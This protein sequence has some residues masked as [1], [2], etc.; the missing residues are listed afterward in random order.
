MMRILQLSLALAVVTTWSTG[1]FAQ[2]RGN[3]QVGTISGRVLGRDGAPAASLRVAAMS[4]DGNVTGV[5]ALL[6]LAETDAAGLYTLTNVRPG[7]YYVV[8][9]RLDTPTYFPGV[10]DSNGATAVTVAADQVLTGID[11]RM[12]TVPGLRFAGR[13]L[14]QD[15]EGNV[16]PAAPAGATAPLFQA[17]LGYAGTARVGLSSSTVTSY[18]QLGTEGIVAPDGTFQFTNLPPGTYQLTLTP[19]INIQ[20]RVS[21]TL[22][23]RDITDYQFI[24]PLV[25]TV[26]GTLAMEGGGPVPRVQME[27]ADVSVRPPT[28]PASTLPVAPTRLS[29]QPNFTAQLRAGDQRVNLINIPQGYTLKSMTSGGVDLT[30]NPF[31]VGPN[32]APLQIVFSASTPS[33]WVRAAGRV[34]GRAEW[35]ILVNF[36]VSHPQVASTLEPIFYLD[37]SFEFPM[38]LPGDI[39]VRS[40]AIGGANLM[41]I[42]MARPGGVENAVLHVPSTP[43]STMGTA[44][45][46]GMQAVRINGRI[47]GKALATRGARVRL[48]NA[49]LGETFN[50]PLYM[51]G[52]FEFPRVTP[53]SYTAEVYPP[54]PGATPTPVTVGDIDIRDLRILLPDTRNLDGRV[55]MDGNAPMPRTISFAL[56]AGAP[57]SANIRP[58]GSFQVELP[59]GQRVG[60][61]ASAVPRGQSLASMNYG[62]VNLMSSPLPAASTTNE[63]RVTFRSTAAPVR[64]TGRVSGSAA[65]PSGAV[66]WLVDSAGVYQTI[67]SA[68]ATDRTFA[69]PAVAPGSYTARFSASGA[70]T[71]ASTPVV[72][73]GNNVAGVEIAP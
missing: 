19:V 45:N 71:T 7:R 53:G 62:D 22:T 17:A 20:Q 31:K 38:T 1:T 49:T 15:N 42:V 13:V 32:A 68:V 26:A 54:V 29:P 52:S 44:P 14:R 28:A 61:T 24:V 35:H 43:P 65:L 64:V 56:S 47:V 40:N 67:E 69:F 70:A 50:A 36:N 12:Q 51:D 11:F 30:R 21:V 27:I 66:V 16:F 2:V 9:G 33:P 37:G 34:E 18:R 46:A 8:A 23:D 4:L 58:D 3:T 60:L 39:Q 55:V 25:V 10:A 63:I 41:S 72:V 73:A 6:S 59:L 5:N 48:R 57:V